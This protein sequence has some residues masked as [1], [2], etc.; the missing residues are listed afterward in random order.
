MVS[1]TDYQ[2]VSRC[3]M[4]RVIK[5]PDIRR[6]ELL[7]IAAERFGDKGYD[8]T[9][10]DEIIRQAG[11]SKGAFYH[12]FP[13]KEALLEAL[14][15]RAA[16]QALARVTGELE[17]PGLTAL[18]KLR[19]FFGRAGEDRGSR[20]T[21]TFGAIFRPENLALYHRL[22]SAVSA[23][24]ARPLAEVVRQGMTESLFSVDDPVT[25]AEIILA[26]GSVTHDMVAGC[27]SASTADE[28]AV[29]LAGLERRLVQQGIAIDRIL[30]LPDRT[31]QLVRPGSARELFGW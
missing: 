4:P 12:Y 10:V 13:S 5:H 15:G 28:R 11:L 31:V 20:S 7:A 14:A 26:L 3:V 21:A 22:H 25:T 1:Y 30:G 29:A 24:L 16:E 8:G 27:L 2:S 17:A 19:A 6:D 23:V 9:S 18:D